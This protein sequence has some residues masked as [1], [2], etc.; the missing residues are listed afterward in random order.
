MKTKKSDDTH[1]KGAVILLLVYGSEKSWD[2][3][4]FNDSKIKKFDGFFFTSKSKCTGKIQ[5]TLT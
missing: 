5:Q 3:N 4:D 1:C 2:Y